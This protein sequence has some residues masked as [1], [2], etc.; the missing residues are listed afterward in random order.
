MNLW[1]LRSNDF[2]RSSSDD[3]DEEDELELL[4]LALST[5]STECESGHFLGAF[6]A[7]LKVS[8]QL[9]SSA[10]QRDLGCVIPR[11]DSGGDFTQPILLRFAPDV[12]ICWPSVIIGSHQQMEVESSTYNK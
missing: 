12:Y 7:S 11:P 10:K 1:F 6:L 2:F 4:R 5:D 3:D 9:E 8:I